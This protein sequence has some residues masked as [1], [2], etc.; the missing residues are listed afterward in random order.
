MSNEI[1]FLLYSLP[2]EE[3]KVQVII[4]DE[5]IWCTQ[6]AMAQLFGVGVPAISKHLKNIFEEKELDKEVVV[7]KMEITAAYGKGFTA[8]S[9]LKLLATDSK[10]QSG[11]RQI[12]R[13]VSDISVFYIRVEN[14]SYVFVLFPRLPT[15]RLAR[16]APHLPCFRFRGRS[17]GRGSENNQDRG[18]S[19]SDK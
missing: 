18:P 11:Q 15:P 5:T 3:G 1:Q 7:S 19:G 10:I 6:K 14:S 4:K 2:D 16:Y 17:Y 9:I 8:R 13:Y 12:S